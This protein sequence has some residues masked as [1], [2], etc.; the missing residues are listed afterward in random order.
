ML[1]MATKKKAGPKK[2]PVAQAMVALRNK[3]LTAKERK[4]IAQKAAQTR[5]K[6]ERERATK[7]EE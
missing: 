5:W 4:D 1:K 7:K 6:G 2:N 3:K